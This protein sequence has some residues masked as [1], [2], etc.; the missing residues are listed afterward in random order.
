MS[1][2]ESDGLPRSTIEQSLKDAAA[3]IFDQDQDNLT[4]KR[5]RAATENKL[6]LVEG[7]FK[8]HSKW[9]PRSKEIVTS[10]VQELEKR[11]G[12]DI[13]SASVAK[14]NGEESAPKKGKKSEPPKRGVKRASPEVVPTPRKKK[15]VAEPEPG[16]ESDAA[17]SEPEESADEAPS[18][19]KPKPKP[20]PKPK[21]NGK[22]KAAKAQVKKSKAKVVSESEDNLD[23]EEEPA[24]ATK[25]DPKAEDHQAPKDIE[26]PSKELAKPPADDSSSE[27]SS[28]IDD[29]PPPKKKGPKKSTSPKDPKA[30]KSKPA[31]EKPESAEPSDPNAEE[32]KRLQGWLVKCG[33]R[34]VWGKEL[35]PYSSPREK[36]AHLKQM[37]KDVGMDGR[38]SV[39]KAR[40]IKEQREL[41]A[42]LEAV[43]DFDER[44]GKKEEQ[45]TR[46]R[47]AKRVLVDFSDDEDSE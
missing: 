19:P 26:E 43:K 41:A 23:D 22:E 46:M 25:E 16:E 12:K 42:D 13:A 1:D 44:W 39:E 24:T 11:E 32:V 35:A 5:V 45:E 33:I 17:L 3:E 15:K 4:L 9:N 29:P 6:R 10:Y 20:E 7:W 2:S 40:Q 36:I 30:P 38:Y 37:L 8:A 14:V 18:K 21:K 28:V 31:K 27:L 34:K 47:G